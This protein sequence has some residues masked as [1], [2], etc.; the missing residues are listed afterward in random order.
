MGRIAELLG[1]RVADKA[2]KAYMRKQ[3]EDSKQETQ[4]DEPEFKMYNQ[5]WLLKVTNQTGYI[6]NRDREK[7]QKILDALNRRNGFCPCGGNGNQYKCPCL[8]MRTHGICK[9]GLF[10][11]VTPVSPTGKSTAKIKTT[12]E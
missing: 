11:N 1:N 10:E 2:A 9:C 4:D 3:H 8:N 12:E 6:V 7:A 5:S